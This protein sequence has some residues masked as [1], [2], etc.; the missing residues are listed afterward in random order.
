MH[1]SL[2]RLVG[3]YLEGLGV[4]TLFLGLWH[5]WEWW[6]W[7]TEEGSQATVWYAPLHPF[8]NIGRRKNSLATH[9]GHVIL[10][11]HSPWMRGQTTIRASTFVM[12]V[13][14]WAGHLIFKLCSLH[15]WNE[16]NWHKCGSENVFW[17]SRKSAKREERNG[18]N[19]SEYF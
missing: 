5:C 4:K 16:S 3:R 19:C 9:S 7:I 1:M 8:P 6:S 11:P 12:V 2:D 15:L 13:P 14:Q 18:V 10:Y 17:R